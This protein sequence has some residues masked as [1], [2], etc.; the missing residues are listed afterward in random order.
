MLPFENSK[1]LFLDSF[2]VLLRKF[3]PHINIKTTGKLY[4]RK[5]STYSTTTATTS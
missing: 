1:K 2:V 4:D 3:Y 5:Q